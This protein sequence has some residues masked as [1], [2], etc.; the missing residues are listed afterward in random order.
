LPLKCVFGAE[1]I[2][3]NHPSGQ[4]E[5]IAT[6]DAQPMDASEPSGQ[7][8]WR[9]TVGQLIDPDFIRRVTG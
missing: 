8:Q 9:E 3:G 1:W 7:A 6:G 5:E 4:G 2:L